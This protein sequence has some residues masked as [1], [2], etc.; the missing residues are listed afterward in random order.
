MCRVGWWWFGSVELG[1]PLSF[2]FAPIP[3]IFTFFQH[4]VD[5]ICLNTT[6][7]LTQHHHITLHILPYYILPTMLGYSLAFCTSSYLIER[8]TAWID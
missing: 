3:F 6:K 2:S 1:F 7:K 4:S 5:F 8:E